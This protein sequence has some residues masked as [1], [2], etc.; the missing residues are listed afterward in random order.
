[1]TALWLAITWQL[2]CGIMLLIATGALTVRIM[3]ATPKHRQME[4]RICKGERRFVFI[5]IQP[6]PAPM[7]DFALYNC[8]VCSGT[9]AVV[10]K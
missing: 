6:A 3:R 4:C 5:G 10:D 1:M 7:K 2:W 9:R 8:T